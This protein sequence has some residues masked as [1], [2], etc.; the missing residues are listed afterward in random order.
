M[1]VISVHMELNYLCLKRQWFN[2]IRSP[3]KQYD[4]K[5]FS[6]QHSCTNS[7]SFKTLR[8][9]CCCQWNSVGE[10]R[11][12][13]ASSRA[14]SKDGKIG[15]SHPLSITFIQ[16]QEPWLCWYF[17]VVLLCSW[18]SVGVFLLLPLVF[19]YPHTGQENDFVM[20]LRLL[21]NCCEWKQNG[22]HLGGSGTALI[23]DLEMSH[24]K[25]EYWSR[26]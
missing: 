16:V 26:Q 5:S 19:Q 6:Y 21:A 23:M 17:T 11:C 2:L 20:P 1:R 3:W 7:F 14:R 18:L 9:G 24:L 13:R 4:G 12:F 22:S 15:I 8:E 10:K 25:E